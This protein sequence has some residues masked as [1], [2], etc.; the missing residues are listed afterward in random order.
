MIRLP[1]PVEELLYHRT[2]IDVGSGENILSER[3]A[4]SGQVSEGFMMG[5]PI[6]KVILHL[7]H[8]SEREVALV[9]LAR[10]GIVISD[11]RAGPRIRNHRVEI[12]RDPPSNSAKT[13]R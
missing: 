8:S 6:T 2:E 12:P 10:R 9:Y 5:M 13:L 4:W 3:R 7:I 11:G 1:Q